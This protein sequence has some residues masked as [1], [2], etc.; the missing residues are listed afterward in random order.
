VALIVDG[1]EAALDSRGKSQCWN[2]MPPGSSI[3]S[4]VHSASSRNSEAV[5]SAEFSVLESVSGHSKDRSV[6]SVD[7]SV[8]AGS[9]LHSAEFWKLQDDIPSGSYLGSEDFS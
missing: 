6:A 3:P 2:S 4:S 1:E 5:V 9:K 7:V 8:E